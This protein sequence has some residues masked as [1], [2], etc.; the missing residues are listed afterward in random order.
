MSELCRFHGIVIVMRTREHG[1]PHFH[2]TGGG[3]EA[4]VDIRTLEI[5]R[6][7]L[8]NTARRLVLAWARQRQPELREAWNRAQR[9]ENPGKIAPLD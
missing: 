8:P 4:Y 6:G 2:A 5:T 9:G 7:R 1:P 3:A